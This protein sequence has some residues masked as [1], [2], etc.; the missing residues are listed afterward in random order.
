MELQVVL[1][2]GGADGC[3]VLPGAFGDRPAVSRVDGLTA[4]QVTAAPTNGAPAL[5]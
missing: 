1:T 5:K 4:Y 3:H 2:A